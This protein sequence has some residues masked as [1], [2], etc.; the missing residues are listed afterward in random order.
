MGLKNRV[1][2]LGCQVKLFD[3]G[4]EN[5]FW[6]E[7]SRSSKN[8]GF[9]REIEI[10]LWSG[11]RAIKIEIFTEGSD[12]ILS[13]RFFR[14]WYIPGKWLEHYWFS[15]SMKY[16][17]YRTFLTDDRYPNRQGGGI[18]FISICHNQFP[19]SLSY[20]KLYQFPLKFIAMNNIWSPEFTCQSGSPTFNHS[21]S[22]K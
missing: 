17:H 6:F 2:K 20:L 3:W 9:D 8:R 21:A 1:V 4:E 22:T 14:F 16:V 15:L 7:L 10:S 5:D 18:W 11:I 19:R 13:F 12:W